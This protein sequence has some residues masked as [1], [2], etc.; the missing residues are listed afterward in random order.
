MRKRL[1]RIGF[2]FVSCFSFLILI[3]GSVA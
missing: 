2:F 3:G 1:N